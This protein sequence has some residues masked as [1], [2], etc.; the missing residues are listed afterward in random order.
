MR[1]ISSIR[2]MAALARM[3]ISFLNFGATITS[4]RNSS[5]ANGTNSRESL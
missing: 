3:M 5:L 2:D 1:G 4:K